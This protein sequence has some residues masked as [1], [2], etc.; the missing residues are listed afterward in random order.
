MCSPIGEN[1]L[2]SE[3]LVKSKLLGWLLKT[4]DSRTYLRD[5]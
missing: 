5:S 4:R 3:Q 2:N 1:I